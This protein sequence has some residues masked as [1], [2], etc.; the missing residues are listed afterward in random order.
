[1]PSRHG[2]SSQTRSTFPLGWIYERYRKRSR[3]PSDGSS[4]FQYY[5]VSS[6]RHDSI[7]RLRLAADLSTLATYSVPI[8]RCFAM[9]Y[10]SH[11]T[12]AALF[13]RHRQL[14]DKQVMCVKVMTLNTDINIVYRPRC[15]YDNRKRTEQ[16]V[17]INQRWK[18]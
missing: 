12:T 5:C 7:C 1:M 17:T 2:G 4:P 8:V 9:P 18:G 16:R 14:Q 10:E 3:P 11:G 6:G 13:R 15:R